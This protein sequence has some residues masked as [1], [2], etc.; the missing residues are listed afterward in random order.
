MKQNIN[1]NQ[2][3]LP[4]INNKHNLGDLPLWLDIYLSLG[5]KE[6]SVLEWGGGH[7]R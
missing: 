1:L 2:L 3:S 4:M 5:K 7:R 6:I